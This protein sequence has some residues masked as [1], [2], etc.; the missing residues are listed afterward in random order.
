MGRYFWPILLSFA[1]FIVGG[2]GTSGIPN[3]S[4][5]KKLDSSVVKIIDYNLETNKPLVVIKNV[6][7]KNLK[8][9]KIK[10]TA[11]DGNGNVLGVREGNF[12]ITSDLAMTPGQQVGLELTLGNGKFPN[13]AKLAWEITPEEATMAPPKVT[14]LNSNMIIDGKEPVVSGEIKN[15]SD[16]IT[17]ANMYIDYFKQ[18]KIIGSVHAV[19]ADTYD[20][21][22]G[23]V[24]SFSEKAVFLTQKPDKYQIHFTYTKS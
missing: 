4:Q 5:E 15:Q 18:G 24:V 14:V 8:D 12:G 9:V 16:Q 2:C 10:L 22:P 23:K 13:N 1:L 11:K 3:Q 6:S 7:S 17:I 20:M 21:S 19:Y